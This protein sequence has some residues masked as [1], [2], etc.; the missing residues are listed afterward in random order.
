MRKRRRASNGGVNLR[1]RASGK[2][3]YYF[4]ASNKHIVERGGFATKE[5]ARQ[6]G[7]AAI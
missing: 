2:W 1:Q 5:E 3:A 6:A 4:T 7:I